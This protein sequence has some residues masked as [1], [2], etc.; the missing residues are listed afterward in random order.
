MHKG[1]QCSTDSIAEE[2]QISTGINISTQAV[3]RELSWIESLW[4][5]SY[6]QASS[7]GVKHTT[8]GFGSSGNM[9]CD[10]NASLFA[11]FRRMSPD[12][13]VPT[14]KFD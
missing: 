3:Q 8:T 13:I 11:G 14:G 4:P 9:F 10:N 1:Q 6:M 2:V 5:N 7:A 12:C